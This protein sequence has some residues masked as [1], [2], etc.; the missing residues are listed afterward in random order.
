MR[1]AIVFAFLAVLV[2]A[3]PPPA[4]AQHT[5]LGV[6]SEPEGWN[7]NLEDQ[8]PGLQF[9][10]VFL[11]QTTGALGVRFRVELSPDCTLLYLEDLPEGLWTSGNV[12]D[13][14]TICFDQCVPLYQRRML[15]RITYYGFGT[16]AICSS[17]EIKPIG[18]SAFIEAVSCDG[19]IHAASGF[20]M[21]VNNAA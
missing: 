4:E 12:V 19:T 5:A 17:M 14:V 10:Y 16:S 8:A 3:L 15:A 13:G 20:N 18:P 9:A 7:C 11:D 6:Y 21:P 2:T 1:T